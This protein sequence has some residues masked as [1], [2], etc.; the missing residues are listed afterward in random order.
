MHQVGFHYTDVS[1]CTVNKTKNTKVLLEKLQ[2]PHIIKTFPIFYDHTSTTGYSKPDQSIP[3]PNTLLFK[4]NLSIKFM[5]NRK[6]DFKKISTLSRLFTLRASIIHLVTRCRPQR[7]VRFLTASYIW[8]FCVGHLRVTQRHDCKL[9]RPHSTVI[10]FTS[11]NQD[12]LYTA[13]AKMVACVYTKS[14]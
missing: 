9:H 7:Q 4:L 2:G 14:S 8:N 13:A 11:I 6:L 3:H 5:P 12:S 10:K 1:R